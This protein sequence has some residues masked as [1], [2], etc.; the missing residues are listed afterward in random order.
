MDPAALPR[1]PIDTA[2]MEH[3][4]ATSGWFVEKDRHHPGHRHWGTWS[5]LGIVRELTAQRSATSCSVTVG[6]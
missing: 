1:S 4:I 2:L 5:A 3:P 6:M